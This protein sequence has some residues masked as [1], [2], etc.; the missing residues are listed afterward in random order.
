MRTKLKCPTRW[1][2]RRRASPSFT[3]RRRPTTSTPA[4]RRS[5]ASPLRRARFSG[6][7]LP[8]ARRSRFSAQ[9]PPVMLP[10]AMPA[11]PNEQPLTPLR[12]QID[13]LDAQIVE[14]LNQRAKVVVEIGKV[15][16][17]SNA[18]IY[19]PDREKAVLQKLRTLNKGP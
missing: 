12:Q 8:F 4:A 15:K 13:A 7:V 3:S 10:S 6:H 19:A 17:Q 2:N 1:S 9:V 14:L 18:P 11:D 5:T 16:Q